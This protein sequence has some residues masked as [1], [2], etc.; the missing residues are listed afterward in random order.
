MGSSFLIINHP[1]IYCC[2]HFSFRL[3]SAI[4]SDHKNESMDSKPRSESFSLPYTV[5]VSDAGRSSD[6]YVNLALY[7]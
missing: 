7:I 6:L 2:H 4:P 5:K 3:L 1:A